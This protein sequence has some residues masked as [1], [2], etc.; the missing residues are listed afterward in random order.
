MFRCLS[1]KIG[2]DIGE[3]ERIA[4]ALGSASR[5]GSIFTTETALVGS[6]IA[7]LQSVQNSF[8][9]FRFTRKKGNIKIY[10]I[11]IIRALRERCE[12][13]L[14][15]KEE[16]KINEVKKKVLWQILVSSGRG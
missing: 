2:A 7:S 6:G 5:S 13:I 10:E 1:T 16:C 15:L 9:R 11:R 3:L 4:S 14:S 12:L 8:W